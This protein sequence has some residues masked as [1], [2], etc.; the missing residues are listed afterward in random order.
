[1]RPDDIG[2]MILIPEGE[3][4][5]GASENDKRT[6]ERCSQDKA[7]LGYPQRKVNL[8]SYYIDKYPVTV[9]AYLKFCNATGHRVPSGE[10]IFNEPLDL[11]GILIG[12]QHKAIYF[13]H[14]EKDF[15][16]RTMPITAVSYYDALAYASWV[17][18][19]LPTEAEWEKAARGTD[20]RSYPWG[21]EMPIENEIVRA[22]F[23]NAMG[24]RTSG[25][26]FGLKYVT[27]VWAFER[28][29]S[30]YGA[31]DMSGNVWEW[32]TDD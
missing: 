19:R 27:H 4:L 14:M 30:P 20:G 31:M 10:G 3:F 5:M 15:G 11:G 7:C 13:P 22:N 2:S 17:R 32:T 16:Q 8:Q 26:D 28:G 23:W 21:E 1:M 24:G 6:L 18:K 29:R 9:E 12:K 25:S